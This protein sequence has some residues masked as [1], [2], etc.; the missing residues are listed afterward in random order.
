MS[1]SAASFHAGFD[2]AQRPQCVRFRAALSFLLA[3]PEAF[4]ASPGR[5]RSVRGMPP[6]LRMHV[7]FQYQNEEREFFSQGCTCTLMVTWIIRRLCESAF[8]MHGTKATG[9]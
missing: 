7:P 8:V 6:M 3:K 2:G 1:S 5:A 4:F 9:M